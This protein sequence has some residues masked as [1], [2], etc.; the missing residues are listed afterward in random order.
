MVLSGKNAGKKALN[1]TIKSDCLL[2][3]ALFNLSKRHIISH[4]FSPWH[5]KKQFS[6]KKI[7]LWRYGPL[8]GIFYP[9]SHFLRGKSKKKNIFF[10]KKKGKIKMV[11]ATEIYSCGIPF[12]MAISWLIAKLLLHQVHIFLQI[13]NIVI[14]KM[15][16][17]KEH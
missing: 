6:P 15:K 11:S 10:C 17:Q 2:R 16:V 12:P 1:Y 8:K 5:K 4:F 7:I 13:D 14:K 9:I 3:L